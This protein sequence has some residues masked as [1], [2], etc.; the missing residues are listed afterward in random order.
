[1]GGC[2][3]GVLIIDG[4]PPT[5]LKRY[6]SY[7]P[8]MLVPP[9]HSG[10][11]H[12]L[13]QSRE[14]AWKKRLATICGGRSIAAPRGFFFGRVERFA[15]ISASGRANGSARF[16]V[17]LTNW[18]QRILGNRGL[19]RSRRLADADCVLR[20]AR[21]F[22]ALQGRCRPATQRRP[23]VGNGMHSSIAEDIRRP[24]E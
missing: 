15:G 24:P 6:P 9:T 12:P 20:C 10:L 8:G 4:A 3:G 21:V 5:V 18:P 1:M 11:N 14:A 13:L 2:A 22:W 23:A 16:V 7:G 19:P 17:G